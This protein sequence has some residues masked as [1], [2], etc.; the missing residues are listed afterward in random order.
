M[1]RP[2]DYQDLLEY[3]GGALLAALSVVGFASTFVCGGE[4]TKDM[5]ISPI[6]LVFLRFAIAG[7]AMLA[8]GLASSRTRPALFALKPREWKRLLWLGPIGTTIMAW[9][10][11]EGCAR[12]PVANASMA[13]ALS[14]LG[15]FATEVNHLGHEMR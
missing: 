13:D 6:V 15:I 2:L 10:V 8:T 12:V 1:E 4:L 11:F 5:G 14:P 3:P 7:G 9:C